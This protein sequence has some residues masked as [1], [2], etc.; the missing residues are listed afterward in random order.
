MPEHKGNTGK[1]N[2]V[3]LESSI[4]RVIWTSGTGCSG[5]KV[6]LEV[7]THFVGNNSEI[8]IEISDKSGK[9]FETVKGKISGNLFWTEI[10]VPEKAKDE[11]YAE[12]KLSKHGLSKKSN[13]MYLFPAIQIKNLK[14][15]KIEVRRGDVLKLTADVT[16]VYDEAEAEIQIW[17]HDSDGAHDLITKFP[18][19]VKKGKIETD[20]EYEYHEDTDDIPTDDEAENGYQNPEYFFRVSLGSVS[21]DSGLLKFKDTIE[22]RWQSGNND[23][24]SNKKFKIVTADGNEINDSFDENGRYNSNDIPPG[25]FTIVLEDDDEDDSDSNE[26]NNEEKEIK[27]VLKD[28]EENKYSNK[29]FEIRFGQKV[30]S[31][32]TDGNGKIQVKV[33]AKILQVK[34]L[35]WLR[36]GEEKASYSTLLQLQDFDEDNNIGS[37]QSKLQNLGYYAGSI[38]GENGNMTKEAIK[39]FQQ[40]NNL[41]VNGEIDPE[42][43]SKISNKFKNK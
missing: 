30:L 4:D 25:P 11:L 40:K 10:L 12:V 34:L 32:N 7:N 15:D 35:V 5:A 9:T 22:V 2:N 8:K 6:G 3:K 39:L 1:I 13:C 28:Q 42:L 33:P 18:V 19:V 41:P 21:E 16:N 31:G 38:D 24:A 20:W 37:V 43:N 14:W 23:K 36:D 29:K 27:I 17:E 26:N